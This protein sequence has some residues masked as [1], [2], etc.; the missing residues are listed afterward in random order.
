MLLSPAN[1]KT[2]APRVKCI[3][4]DEIYS[5]GQADDDLVWEQ[6]L[7]LAPCRIIALSATVGNPT[8]LA[9]WISVTQKSLGIDLK[10]VQYGQRYSDL[11]KYFS[12]P[13]K[14]DQV[15]GA[16]SNDT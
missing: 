9:D 10:L 4:F 5:I 13:P 11:G 12:T 7:L 14:K 8:E 1:A 15:P 6:L 3:V 2:G 16:S